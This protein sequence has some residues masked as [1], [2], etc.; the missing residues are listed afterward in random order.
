MK[1]ITP[2]LFALLAL[3]V[4]KAT[5]D[6][7]LTF[8][9]AHSVDAATSAGDSP[10][11]LVKA[12]DGALYAATQFGTTTSSPN[13]NFDGEAITDANGT[14][15]EGSPY[16]GSSNNRNLLLQ[17][18][19]SET[20]A[21]KWFAYTKK[22]DVDH[23]ATLI[24]PSS[25]GGVVFAAKTRAWVSE[26]G[27]DNLLEI[28]DGTG[29]T[30]TIKDMWTLKSE[31][32][33]I[34]AKLDANGKLV[35]ARLVSGLVK[36]ITVDSKTTTTKENFTI[37]GLALDADDNVYLAGNFRTEINFKKADGS[38]ETLVAKNVTNWDGSTTTAGDLFIAKLEK[39]NGYFE[40]SLTA[41]GTATMA[42]I[43]N[44]VYNDGTLYFNGR[45][46]GD[47]TTMTLGGKEINASSTLQTQ[48]IGSVNASDLSV[49]YVNVLKTMPNSSSKANIQN[50]NI[51]YID[52]NIYLTGL[53]NGGF[54]NDDESVIYIDNTTTGQLRG[55]LLKMNAS[56]GKIE[57]S[58]LNK[59]AGISG[60][61]GVYVA[62]TSTYAFGYNMSTG[63]ILTR[64]SNSD[65]SLIADTVICKY[66]TVS[67]CGKPAIDGDNF[68]M[69]NRG[70]GSATFFGSETSFSSTTWGNV[71]YS[72]KIDDTKTGINAVKANVTAN[73]DVYT[74]EGIQVKTASTYDEAVKNLRAGTYIIGGKKVAVE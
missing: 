58:Y 21:V 24:A 46:Q 3:T 50:K 4:T 29:A 1:K 49:N 74:L 45:V 36:E 47:G 28:V 32:R 17:K 9:W 6:G 64:I 26:A 66:G 43:D 34:V 68:V 30:T 12:S 22:G 13:V 44:I 72:Y 42:Y 16:T 15:I 65:Y 54:A 37:Y 60:Y 33:Y 55:Y 25:D 20:A 71:Y 53:V 51:Q 57:S 5:A 56:T 48:I 67:L 10:I 31:Y 62:S 63:A 70:K 11:G 35:W 39:E 19:D 14:A 2:L 7:N 23:A 61:F 38:V 40:T 52:G 27:L 73:Y 69:M 18:L 41:E 59:A 8:N